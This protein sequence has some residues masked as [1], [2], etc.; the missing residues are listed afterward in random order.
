MSQETGGNPGEVND[1]SQVVADI[2]KGVNKLNMITSGLNAYSG[3]CGTFKEAEG[4]FLVIY[5][6]DSETIEINVIEVEVTGEENHWVVRWGRHLLAV[7]QNYH[8]LV[9]ALVGDYALKLVKVA[10]KFD[11]KGW[12]RI[13]LREETK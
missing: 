13:A 1:L 9:G 10:K 6:V 11:E 3:K 4:G 5:E 12:P 2:R 7:C 8:E